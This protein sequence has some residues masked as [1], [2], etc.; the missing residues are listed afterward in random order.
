MER[1]STNG[2]AGNPHHSQCQDFT[3]TKLPSIED[4][5]NIAGDLLFDSEALDAFLDTL[6]KDKDTSSVSVGSEEGRAKIKSAAHSVARY[7]SA[8]DAARK[9]ATEDLRKKTSEIN[10]RGNEAIGKLADLQADIRRP[11]DQWE[12]QEK[13]RVA[14]IQSKLTRIEALGRIVV[15]DTAST[16][17]ERLKELHATLID[18]TTFAEQTTTALA[19]RDV[20]IHTL[21]MELPRRQKAEADAAELE[22]LRRMEADL[23]RQQAEA[24]R[25]AEAEALE[26]ARKEAEDKR[27]AEARA[28]AEADAKAAAERK[29]KEEAERIQREADE[30]VRAAEREAQEKIEAER[31][32]AAA[33]AD[34]ERRVREEADRKAAEA[35]AKEER[36][37]ANEKHRAKVR[38]AAVKHLHDEMATGG[39]DEVIVLDLTHRAFDAIADGR[40]PNVVVE[41]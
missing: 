23:E 2:S 13:A 35:K 38:A 26:R 5:Q 3:M 18:K 8:L 40:I 11:L 15:D 14:E 9:T 1:R 19:A 32:K 20:A 36:R 24:R 12:V 28:A 34:A 16:V 25:K 21:E 39:L 31:Q 17:A 37:A 27:I 22:R 6:K 4:F 7:K 41:F 30:R 10:A 33:L 29:A